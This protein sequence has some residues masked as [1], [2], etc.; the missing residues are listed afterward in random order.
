MAAAVAA[1]L[2]ASGGVPGAPRTAAIMAIEAVAPVARPASP[3]PAGHQTPACDVWVVRNALSSPTA[4]EEA[5]EAVERVGCR[6]IYLQVSG[7]WD[8]FYPSQVFGPPATT[9]FAPG[10]EDPFG[11]ALAEARARGIEVHA[12]VN[13]MLAWSAEEPPP[14]GHVFRNHPDWFVTDAGGRS[15]RSLSRAELDR[16][17]LRGEGW[18]VD[19]A[20][21]E[22]RTELR[23]FILELVLRY[24]VDGVHLDY[25]RYPA[26]WAPEGGAGSVGYLVGLI[27]DDLAQ[28]R[29]GV[30]LTAAVLPVPELARETFGQD[31]ADWLRRGILDEAVPMV[32]REDAEAVLEVVDAYPDELERGRLRIGVRLDGIAP[33]EVRRAAAELAREGVPGVA[34]FSHNLLM[35]ARTWRGVTDLLA[36]LSR[37]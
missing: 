28:V 9:P 34:L 4:W 3:R 7:R 18:F 24:P 27:R 6:R 17:G 14:A 29:P 15:M 16:R 25:I 11:E 10:W 23:R 8:A 2:A 31:W 32:Y 21:L 30:R 13:A 5:L 35:E 1:M 20:V 22:V 33:G 36:G 12:W 26:G 37:P 19:P